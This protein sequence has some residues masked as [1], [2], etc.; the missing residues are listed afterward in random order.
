[1]QPHVPG[2]K[3]LLALAL[4]LALVAIDAASVTASPPG[5]D[6]ALP[7]NELL[8]GGSS[9][10]GT[11]A[12]QAPDG[13]TSTGQNLTDTFSVG[14]TY[15][16]IADPP[17][18]NFWVDVHAGPGYGF[19]NATTSADNQ[20]FFSIVRAP[21]TLTN[22]SAGKPTSFRWTIDGGTVST[23]ESF[24]FPGFT[25]AGTHVVRLY[26]S[27]RFGESSR[28]LNVNVRVPDA[29]PVAAFTYT[30]TTGNAPL[31]VMFTDTSTHLPASWLWIFDDGT[32]SAEQNPTHTFTAPGTYEVIL[33][34]TN[35]KGSDFSE[36]KTVTVTA[37]P[38]S[39][40]FWVDV[41]AGPGYGFFNAST[42]ADNQT[43][44]SIVRAPITFSNNSAGKPTSFRWTIDG[45]TVS[46]A[47]SF[48]FPG[49]TTAGTHVVRLNASNQYGQSSRT[50]NVNVRVPDAVPVA[51]FTY[52]PTTGNAPLAVKFTDTSTH[53]PASWLW[54]FD[55]GTTSAEQNPTHTFTVPGTYSVMLRATNEKGADFS[56]EKTVAVLPATL[57]K[58]PGG[59]G[60]PTDTGTDGKYDDV[61][62]NGR[63]DFADVVLYFN[64]MTWIAANE[65]LSAFDCNGNGRIDFAD[66]VWLFNN[67]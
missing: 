56:E 30:P 17:S 46:T 54:I 9:G 36:E 61:N 14:G 39:V 49:F 29:V 51:A 42:S 20:T 1:M 26:A 44:F 64:Q 24:T 65:P 67:L 13:S 6:S 37:D 27:N 16:I 41:H 31:A 57:V 58:I 23:A 59:A 66:V 2:G 40:N 60:V 38:P 25:T 3:I 53:L 32:T 33:R 21:I 11:P 47:E 19:F 45:G 10:Y 48:T 43:F 18:V 62:G 28:T 52:T 34:A 15:T 5:T 8:G 50:L 35:E 63:K 12:Q 55:D 4:V 7:G 22:N